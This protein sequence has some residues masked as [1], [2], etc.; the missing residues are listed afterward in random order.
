MLKLRD[1]LFFATSKFFDKVWLYQMS[2]NTEM[3]E[4][5]F[6]LRQQLNS[7]SD[8]SSSDQQKIAESE[9]TTHKTCCDELLRKN[10]EG[11]HEIWP[12]EEAY[13]GENTPKSV[14]SLNR[15]F[16]Q[17]DSKDCNNTTFLNSQVLMQVNSL[18]FIC[19]VLH[20]H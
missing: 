20:R 1:P 7:L 2:E 16:S 18:F 10:K 11:R 8:N 12:C 5:I 17:E 9:S 19:L 15:M 13:A 3:Q 6:L 4:T 14:M